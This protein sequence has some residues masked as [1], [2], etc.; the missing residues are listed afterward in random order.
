MN[1][2]AFYQ[3]L[4]I[5]LGICITGTVLWA[6]KD[7]REKFA[8]AALGENTTSYYPEV[9]GYPIHNT[10][11][12][13][14][15]DSAMEA[16]WTARGKK[17]VFLMLGNS[18][19]HAINR[20]QTNDI[21]YPEMLH[22]ADAVPG[23]DILTNSV[24]NASLQE[25][26]LLYTYCSSF[27]PV[28]AVAVPVFLD[29]MRETG[30]RDYFFNPLKASPTLLKKDTGDISRKI[31]RE[32]AVFSQ[33]KETNGEMAALDNTTQE[34]VEQYLNNTLQEKWPMWGQ[35]EQIRGSLFNNLYVF[36][37]TVFGITAQTKRKMVPGNYRDNIKALK[38]LMRVAES[39]GT[40]LLIYIPPLRND[41]APPYDAQEYINFKNE[42]KD[43]V[44]ASNHT[45]LN[46]ENLVPGKE[47]GMKQSTNTTG[48]P[49][50]D[51]MHFTS[52][53][54]QLL[55]DTFKFVLPQFI[56]K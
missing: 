35:R 10:G 36:R 13:I 26:Y 52:K 2:S 11:V 34:K 12:N 54:H 14:Q 19:T 31:E 30:I 37:N 4:P 15:R 20:K 42:I 24:P 21:N 28:K 29:D 6:Y 45:F 16:G 40:R 55:A 32:V 56:T 25:L 5:L 39:N 48:E 1:K 23:F 7:Q 49:E 27:L 3:L 18:Q 9:G 53:G 44:T 22:R 43:I 50:Y 8:D 46:L 17:P 38:A 51:F 33:V 47:W 41:V